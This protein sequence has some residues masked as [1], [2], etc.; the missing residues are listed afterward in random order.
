MQITS[1][2][3]NIPLNM[4]SSSPTHEDP[5]ALIPVGLMVGDKDYE[6]DVF[7]FNALGYSGTFV[8]DWATETYRCLTDSKIKIKKIANTTDEFV[9]T[10]PEGHHLVFELKEE[11]TFLD[12]S[13]TSFSYGTGSLSTSSRLIGETSSRVYKLT[14][15]Y[16]NQNDHIEYFYTVTNPVEN[17][18]SVSKSITDYEDLGPHPL[19]NQNIYQ[20]YSSGLSPSTSTSYSRTA[21]SFSYLN[22]ITFNAGVVLFT[23]SDR[24]DNVGAKKLDKIEVK[25]SE[26]SSKLI[27]AVDFSYDYFIGHTNGSYYYDT[28]ST[29]SSTENTHRLKL[30]SITEPGKP[31]HIF[32]YNTTPLPRKTS[33]AVDYWGYYNGHSNADTFPNIFRFHYD[34]ATPHNLYSY[35]ANNRS[36]RDTYTKA[37]ILKKISY[38]TGGYTRFYYELNS[39]NNYIVP[40]YEDTSNTVYTEGR[41]SYGAGLR[42]QKIENYNFDHTKISQKKYT[43]QRGKLMTP[44]HFFN[45]SYIPRW[46]YII[47]RSAQGFLVQNLGRGFRRSLNSNSM[48]AP[49]TNASGNFVGYNS[50]TEHL[51]ANNSQTVTIGK[52]KD[53]YENHNDEGIFP[54]THNNQWY[55]HGNLNELNLPTREASLTRNGSLLEQY[56]YDK[57]DSLKQK[58][59]NTYASAIRYDCVNGFKF[60]PQIKKVGFSQEYTTAVVTHMIGAYPIRGIDSYMTSRETIQYM[61]G[62]VIATKQQYSYNS[63]QQLTEKKTTTSVFYDKNK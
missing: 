53:V 1:D 36:S 21:Q 2:E 18:S 44:L 51:L 31:A 33:T 45:K 30:T 62:R 29:K 47:A 35:S 56:M 37:G 39:F 4:P 15:I 6:P 17:F 42:I 46:D 50:V 52:I 55:V 48:M 61:P 60:G 8:L 14:H 20:G 41:I 63:L 7:K 12:Q 26:S 54:I 59:I 40:N 49:S 13:S 24:L 19:V 28:K 11:T 25:S 58:I 22:K 38:P 10:T 43:Y 27:K 23:S 57:Y 5:N 32:E 34:I 16:T 3:F 9:I